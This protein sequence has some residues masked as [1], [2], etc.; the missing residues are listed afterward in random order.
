MG[1]KADTNYNSIGVKS[2]LQITDGKAA[3]G[4]MRMIP[5]DV[6]LNIQHPNGH[7]TA[8]RIVAADAASAEI[9]LA[10]STRWLLTPFDSHLDLPG[11]RPVHS[12]VQVWVIRKRVRG[13]KRSNRP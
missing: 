10:D 5:A 2:T 12:H 8:A 9:R 3:L 6:D 13:L 4:S 1:L 7:I 11:V